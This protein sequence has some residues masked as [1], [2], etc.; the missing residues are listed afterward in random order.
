MYA[1]NNDNNNNN[2][3]NKKDQEKGFWFMGTT[4]TIIKRQRDRY[5]PQTRSDQSHQL[6]SKQFQLPSLYQYPAKVIGRHLMQHLLPLIF[7]KH[8]RS[9]IINFNNI[10]SKTLEC[11]KFM[12]NKMTE[13]G[14][15]QNTMALHFNIT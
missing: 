5:P 3:N 14:L 13:R 15:N 1:N 8:K 9:H 10:G 11:T 7:L 2:K 4:E 12:A 6:C